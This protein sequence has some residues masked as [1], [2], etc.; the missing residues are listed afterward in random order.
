MYECV[1]YCSADDHLHV[2]KMVPVTSLPE[3]FELSYYANVVIP[4]F[5]T[6]S[7][8][9]KKSRLSMCLFHPTYN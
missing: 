9:G 8:I 6:E 1:D 5:A 2:V 7:V 3:I 4:I